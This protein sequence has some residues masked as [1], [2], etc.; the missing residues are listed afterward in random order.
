MAAEIPVD[1]AMK[2]LKIESTP[3]TSNSNLSCPKD[4]NP[5]DAATCISLGDATNNLK[6]SEAGQEGAMAG[7]SFF[8][9]VNE[10][11]G[12]YYPGVSSRE[13]DD[14][15]YTLGSDA[16]E[17]P[18]Q[19]IQTDNASLVYFIPSTQPGYTP[20]PL[21][22][23]AM[24][25]FDGQYVS[26]Q[27]YY[28][29]PIFPQASSPGYFPH[30]YGAELVPTYW[31]PSLLTDGFYGT[32]FGLDPPI[33]SPVL[34]FPSQT[35]TFTPTKSSLSSKSANPTIKGSPQAWGVSPLPAVHNQSLKPINKAAAVLSQ[36]FLPMNK[37]SSYSNHGKDGL[38]HVKE[39]GRSWV[40]PEK[41]KAK[42]RIYTTGD[43]EMLNE[44]N[45]GPRTKGAKS[46]LSSDTDQVA[47]LVTEGNEN[48]NASFPPVKDEY[49]LPD[50][51]TKYDHALFFVIKS[52]SED[53]IHKSIKYN[54]WA[55]TSNGNKRLD[56][57]YQTAQE[58]MVEKG[59]KC[60]VFLF[61]SVNASGQFCGVAEMIGRVD[62]SK[63]MDFWQQDK[64]NG[65][66]P[67]KWHIIKDIPNPQLRHIILENNEN[68]P[69]T[70]SRDTQEV[71]FPQGTDMLN[72]FK[73]YSSKTSIIDD[74]NFYENRQKVMQDKKIRQPAPNV[75]RS[76][77]GDTKS[78][79]SIPSSELAV[80]K[81]K[82]S[83]LLK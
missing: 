73:N 5:S 9:P 36:S 24:I 7:Q 44:Q 55:S 18:H 20:Y 13:C 56:N 37:F 80:I 8:Y 69:V 54:V 78:I 34:N 76:S 67:V 25:N 33:S 83:T 27:P 2:N 66:F 51:P 15:S 68:K 72:I 10:Y 32:G 58:K 16:F 1:D 23:G 43:L 64:W 70:N 59:S 14:Q 31:N 79:H 57:A 22:P 48:L 49:N 74:F 29:T 71:K 28:P 50:F 4:G 53:D 42:T 75:D 3:K 62:Y 63:N 12:Y 65:F 35:H 47:Q 26:Q 77:P 81:N 61:F 52:Y 38:L 40:G 21:L 17:V 82:E 45:C 11:Y 19:A 30:S 46:T 41:P 39:T 60:P 6:E